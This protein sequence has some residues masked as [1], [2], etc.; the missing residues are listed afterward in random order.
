[1]LSVHSR[2]V[3]VRWGA[4]DE[5]PQKCFSGQIRKVFIVDS[6][7]F[8]VQWSL[9]NTSRYPYLDISDLQNWIWKNRTNTFHKRIC[10]LTSEVRDIL[11]ILW[12]RGEIVAYIAPLFHYITK[13]CLCNFDPLKPHFLKLN[14]SLQGYTLFFLF[15]LK[16]IDCGFSLEPPRW[17]GSNEYPQSMFWTEIWKISEYFVRKFSFFGGE[18]FCIFE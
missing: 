15:L 9:W 3:L 10:N 14:W 11:K 7:C 1:M 12:R 17:G 18:I 2:S 8:E 6:R 16:N 5:Y 13:T 4:S